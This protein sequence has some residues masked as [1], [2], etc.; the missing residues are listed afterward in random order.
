MSETDVGMPRFALA[1]R[2]PL[3]G[4]RLSAVPDFVIR[5]W[6]L[7]PYE[8]VQAPLHVHHRGDEAFYVLE[9]RIDVQD[10]DTRHRLEAGQ[11]HVV[12]AGSVHTFATVD[13]EQSARVLVVMTPEI[14]RLIQRLHDEDV[15]HSAV[16]AEHH[17]SLAT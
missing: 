8:G 16:W 11:M 10:G 2:V 7:L 12:E 4:P 9:G 5:E 13:T 14:D 3:A 17:S 1:E 15:D 6:T